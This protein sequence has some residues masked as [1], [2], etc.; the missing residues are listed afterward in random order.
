MSVTKKAALPSFLRMGFSAFPPS[1]RPSRCQRNGKGGADAQN[2]GII[3]VFHDQQGRNLGDSG[4]HE[5]LS[6]VG[7]DSLN[8]AVLGYDPILNKVGEGYKIREESDR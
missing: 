8:Q 1:F 3:Q 6:P 2:Q 5:H 7:D 4:S